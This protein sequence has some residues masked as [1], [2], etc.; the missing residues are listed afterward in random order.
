[1]KKTNA[2]LTDFT[3]KIKNST[4]KERQEILEELTKT[5]DALKNN[6]SFLKDLFALKC[7]IPRKKKNAL[8]K[9]YKNIT[10]NLLIFSSLRLIALGFMDKK[11]A[12][13]L[14]F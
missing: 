4:L 1:M 8:K 10:I 6:R 2:F 12:K 11:S 14:V 5:I 3:L 7:K 13:I 9:E